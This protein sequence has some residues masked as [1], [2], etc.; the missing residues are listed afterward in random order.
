MAINSFFSQII[1]QNTA[2]DCV[3]DIYVEDNETK[4]VLKQFVAAVDS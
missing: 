3:K 1:I 2:R 4:V